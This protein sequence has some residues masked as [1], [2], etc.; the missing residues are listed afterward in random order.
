MS[1]SSKPAVGGAQ[2]GLAASPSGGASQE[3]GTDIPSEVEMVEAEAAWKRVKL[4][5]AGGYDEAVAENVEYHEELKQ[6]ALDAGLTVADVKAPFTTDAQVEFL[7]SFSDEQKIQLLDSALA[8]LYTPPNEHF[9]IVPLEAMEAGCP[10]LA[11]RSGG[12]CETVRHGVTGYLIPSGG[13]VVAG[14][15]AAGLAQSAGEDVGSEI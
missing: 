1:S 15:Y 8:V 10:V 5:V 11:D 7:R 14:A 4:V 3:G 6:M 12:P 9:G 13:A 2:E